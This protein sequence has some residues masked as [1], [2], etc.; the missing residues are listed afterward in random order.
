MV[1]NNIDGSGSTG[2]RPRSRHSAAR[3]YNIRRDCRRDMAQAAS[4]ASATTACNR[5]PI[6]SSSDPDP[7]ACW[8]SSRRRRDTAGG[9]PCNRQHAATAGRSR[10]FAPDSNGCAAPWPTGREAGANRS[11][12]SMGNQPLVMIHQATP[13]RQTGLDC[14]RRYVPPS[15]LL[16]RNRPEKLVR[17]GC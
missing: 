17:R 11:L 5:T 4:H 14:S 1:V 7:T 2:G 15:Y 3:G 16:H 12:G 9:L 8:L 10:R 13:R 6:P